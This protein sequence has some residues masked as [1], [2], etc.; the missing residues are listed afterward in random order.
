MSLSEGFITSPCSLQDTLRG[1]VS[2]QKQ[3]F[4][5][6]HIC[7]ETKGMR[8]ECWEVVSHQGRLVQKGILKTS[9][10]HMLLYFTKQHN[11]DHVTKRANLELNEVQAELLKALFSSNSKKRCTQGFL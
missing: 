1:F 3:R 7:L 11:T 2:P 4:T 6:K 8:A 5:L 9:V 10:H